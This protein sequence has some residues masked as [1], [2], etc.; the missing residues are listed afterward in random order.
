MS[1]VGASSAAIGVPLASLSFSASREPVV[2]PDVRPRTSES[3]VRSQNRPA[4][5]ESFVTVPVDE[6]GPASRA[7]ERSPSGSTGGADEQRPSPVFLV[8]LNRLVA[9]NRVVGASTFPGEEL[10]GLGVPVSPQ[11]SIERQ[12]EKIAELVDRFEEVLERIN[13]VVDGAALGGES[14][15]ALADRSLGSLL[16][17]ADGLFEA[18]AVAANEFTDAESSQSAPG[19]HQEFVTSN[20]RPHLNLV[21]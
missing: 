9:E 17:Q 10:E 19:D 15:R 3:S 11:E 5:Q 6:S 8:D 18:I 21:L 20:L 4:V 1:A 14:P 7:S 16:D 2:L 13:S 12:A